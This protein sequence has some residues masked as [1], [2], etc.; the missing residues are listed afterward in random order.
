MGDS[1]V[2]THISPLV[3]PQFVAFVRDFVLVLSRK[4]VLVLGREKRFDYDHEH[5][6]IE[7]E[8]DGRRK[9]MGNDKGR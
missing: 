8:H 7:H 6:F 5:H 1:L 4:T 9:D 3:S 2:I